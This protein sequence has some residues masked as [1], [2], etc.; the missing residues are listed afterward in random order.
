MAREIVLGGQRESEGALERLQHGGIVI[1]HGDGIGLIDQ[2]QIVNGGMAHIM[3]EAGDNDSQ[4]L[5][6]SEV[7]PDTRA[8]NHHEHLMANISAVRGWMVGASEVV[9]LQLLQESAKT[10]LV[11]IGFNMGTDETLTD[12]LNRAT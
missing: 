6:S 1:D 2:K 3:S 11:V 12:G 7:F 8:W 9:V 10:F 5:M 4:M